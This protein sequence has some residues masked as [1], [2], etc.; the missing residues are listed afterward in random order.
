MGVSFTY[1]LEDWTYEV[2]HLGLKYIAWT[3]KGKYLEI[4][5]SNILIKY[6]LEDK[7][8]HFFLSIIIFQLLI[9]L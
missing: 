9:K 1:V 2:C 3:H 4:P 8:S 7:I 6:G 5:F